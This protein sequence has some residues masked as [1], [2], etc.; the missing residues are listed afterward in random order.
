MQLFVS[1]KEIM[2]NITVSEITADLR[3]AGTFDLS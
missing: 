2:G 1:T 3:F